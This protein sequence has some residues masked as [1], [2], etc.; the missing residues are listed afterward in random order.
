M[1]WL[2]FMEVG[3][4]LYR[5]WERGTSLQLGFCS[6]FLMVSW[7]ILKVLDWIPWYPGYQG[8]LGIRLHFQKNIIPASYLLALAFALKLWGSSEWAL[9]PFV[10]LLMPVFYVS[11]ILLYFHFR[12]SSAMMPGYFTHNFYL[13][14]KEPPWSP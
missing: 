8:K 1:T 12:D 4:L 3:L 7:L 6:I 10:I 9:L 13:N 14:E 2:V 11:G 5:V